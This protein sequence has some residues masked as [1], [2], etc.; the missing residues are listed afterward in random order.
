MGALDSAPRSGYAPV[1]APSEV[2]TTSIAGESHGA[3]FRL[4]RCLPSLAQCYYFSSSDARRRFVTRNAQLLAMLAPQVEEE[5]K[6]ENNDEN[7]AE[8]V[9]L[10]IQQKLTARFRRSP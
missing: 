2:P 10:A 9:R 4:P 8:R 5:L 1:A 7:F 6:Q 3:P